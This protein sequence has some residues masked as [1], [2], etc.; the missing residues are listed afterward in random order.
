MLLCVSGK[1]LTEL[2]DGRRIILEP[3]MSYQLADGIEPHRTSTDA[4]TT[5]FIVD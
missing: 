2:K 5:L 3:G 1:M 4:G